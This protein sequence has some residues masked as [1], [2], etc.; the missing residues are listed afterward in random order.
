MPTYRLDIQVNGRD[1]GASNVLLNLHG[2]LGALGVAMGS[3]AAGG[4]AMLGRAVAGLGKAG[5]DVAMDYQSSLNMFQA[6][7]GATAAQLQQA[8]DLAKQL[9]GDMT[10]PATSA[11]DAA[12]AMTELAKAGLSVNDALA[13][14]KGT[15]Q[16]SAA[17][18]DDEARAAEIAA[19]ALNSFGLAGSKATMV[20]DLF[21]AA[22]NKSSVEVTDIAESFQMASAVF[23]AF[24]GPVVGSE[25]AMKD[26]TTAIAI[27]GN[28]GI[29]GSDA[30][31]S[32]KQMLL[33]L[34]GPSQKAKAEMQGLFYAAMGASGGMESL[35]AILE[36]KAS[37][38]DKALAALAKANPALSKMGD[39]AY[40]A[41]GKMR[42][43]TDII[44]L[45]TLATKGMTD[46]QRNQ[47]LT[48]IFGADATR[49]II[50]LMRAGPDA[51]NAMET[52]ISQQGAASDLA[53]AR[54]KGLAG[55]WEGFKSTL[56]TTALAVMEPLLGPLETG[57]RSL[58]GALSA[59]TPSL[60]AFVQT[61]VVPA[62]QWLAAFLDAFVQAPD[63]IGFLRDQ[64]IQ[65]GQAALVQIQ[66]ALPGWVAGLKQ[67]ALAA[68]R[69]ALD[70]IPDLLINLL[71]LR[72]QAVGWVLG[73]LPGWLDALAGWGRALWQW[74]VTAGPELLQRFAGAQ[75]GLLTAIGDGAPGILTKLGTW[76]EAFLAWVGP[77]AVGLIRN[78]GPLLD[79]V[80][81]WIRDTG[82]PWLGT[83]LAAWAEAFLKWVGPA[84][85]G[86]TLELGKLLG[87]LLTWIVARAPTIAETIGGWIKAAGEWLATKGAPLFFEAVG[88]WAVA[89]IGRIQQLW[90][91]AFADGSLG[92]ALI[93]SIL[94]GLENGWAGLQTWLSNHWQDLLSGIPGIGLSF[95]GAHAA[96]I[97]GFAGGVR[98]FGGGLAVVGERGPELLRL[99][100]GSDVFP[101]GSFGGGGATTISVG[102]IV[103]QG[104]D[105]PRETARQVREELIRLGKRN[106][107]LGGI[108]GGYA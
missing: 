15:L 61:S 98:N 67:W 38:R 64:L 24:Q 60:V 84:S 88:I 11:G 44:R 16:L 55:A 52:A 20:A 68:G 90:G 51:F 105:D 76:V 10:L 83:H 46:E 101:A 4:I 71:E 37:D 1:N 93:D 27:L 80:G 14:A 21:A 75:L 22:A 92:K 77:A 23:S 94:K 54:M 42:P 63:K 87:E 2:G 50:G 26:L 36:G 49:A 58:A 57:V 89:V 78:L 70:A 13:A 106:Q 96:G 8:G 72:N 19:N 32:L 40:D 91:A 43:L 25:K 9:G 33:Q 34:T 39:I 3:L 86:L 104:A 81:A 6:V 95:Q 35:D 47:A 107:G 79:T 7:S 69:W 41:S 103:V 102:Q 28:V 48:T 12:R 59:A 100:G 66:A 62:V 85:A 82:A 56:E 29:K 5:L 53:A 17:G 45:T 65:F 108:F 30:G 99:P 31:T 74:V 97:P 18:V 73:Q